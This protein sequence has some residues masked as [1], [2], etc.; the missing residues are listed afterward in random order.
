MF[1]IYF[2]RIILR[3]FYIFP[4]KKKRVV[5]TSY[6][7]RQYSCS[8][9]YIANEL[10][11]SDFE[12]IF[13]LKKGYVGNL[14]D[15]II[16]VD[17]RSIKHMFYLMTAKYIIVNSTGFTC[18][19]P[20]RKGQVLI[21][22]WHGGG[23]FKTTGIS[24]FNSKSDILKR[25]IIGNNT[26]YFISSSKV[27]GD[28]QAH[29][30]CLSDDKVLDIGTPRNDLFFKEDKNRVIDKVRKTYNISSDYGIVLYCPTYRD[31]EVKSLKD[32][33]FEIIDI[34]RV[35]KALEKR[36][37]KKFIFI[38]R[39]HHDM[40][41]ENLESDCINASSY[42]DVQELLYAADVLITDYS[43]CMWDFG[44]MN[45]PGFLYTPDLKEYDSVHKLA[46]PIEEWPYRN[47]LSNNELV[48]LIINYNEEENKHRLKD[49][50]KRLGSSENGEATRKI[51]DILNSK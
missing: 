22:T 37:N 48:E 9:K 7:G 30:M 36:F 6:N 13:A 51:I 24:Y 29:S 15:N 18:L 42:D 11:N 10:A 49:Y 44:L 47:A 32:Y 5:L 35:L 45:K 41:P 19:L 31:G 27:F 20:F 1:K 43:S 17:Y 12:T 2:M 8:P 28:L 40:V 33:N 38:F 3:I 23:A 14:P 16:R 26:T 50:Y 4:I 39:A 34:H 46:S 21:N 25:R